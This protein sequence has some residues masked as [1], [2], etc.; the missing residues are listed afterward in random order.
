MKVYQRMV[1]VGLGGTGVRIG[2]ALEK[3]LR[4]GLCGPDGS[5]LVNAY[6]SLGLGQWELPEYVRFVYADFD[7]SE[8]SGAQATSGL[9]PQLWQRSTK[10]VS[11]MVPVANSS[12]QVGQS[13][14]VNELNGE[15]AWLPPENSD[16]HVA[17]LSDGAGQFP[18]VGR[19]ALHAAIMD[20]NSMNS[21]AG[22]ILA[23]LTDVARGG[24]Q[25]SELT[26]RPAEEGI[27]VFVGFSVAGGTG[28]GI[29]YDF[30]HLISHLAE[31]FRPLQTKI[32]PLVLLPSTIGKLN[33]RSARAA[34]LNGSRALLALLRLVD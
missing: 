21:V 27:D 18:T 30:L 13:L 9:D 33:D 8:L 31:E 29:F 12:K 10:I 24:G 14:R 6:P 19:A 20:A 15:F 11:K 16:P 34:Q 17:P 5:Q 25:I 3:E 28:C 1:Y 32:Y 7:K 26:G 23:A 2:T 22:P 4:A